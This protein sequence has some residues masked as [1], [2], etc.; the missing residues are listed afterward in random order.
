MANL[1][2]LVSVLAA[3]GCG[4]PSLPSPSSRAL[5]GTLILDNNLWVIRGGLSTQ[6]LFDYGA[7]P[8]PARFFPCAGTG[9]YGDIETG[10]QLTVTDQAGTTIGVGSLVDD[11][12]G[13]PTSSRMAGSHPFVMKC[14]YRFFIGNLP[15][16]SS[17]SLMIG[18]RD[19][20]TYTPADLARSNWVIALRLGP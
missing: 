12:E 7:T 14:F 16:A 9:D 4:G 10:V 15:E 20:P 13:T 5:S 11:R 2:V 1:V 17:Y 8:E 19:G 18:R 3:A 6:Y